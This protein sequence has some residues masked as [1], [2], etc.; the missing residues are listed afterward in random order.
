MTFSTVRHGGVTAT[1]GLLWKE[2]SSECVSN[3]RANEDVATKSRRR[4]RSAR[5]CAPAEERVGT[6]G[7]VL[8]RTARSVTTPARVRSC[9]RGLRALRACDLSHR[10]GRSRTLG[11]TGFSVGA[12]A[13]ARVA[14]VGHLRRR[15][16][17]GLAGPPSE[18]MRSIH[19]V[20]TRDGLE[21]LCL[22][23]IR[24]GCPRTRPKADWV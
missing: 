24:A 18:Y 3:R 19:L 21:T 14:P 6:N 17:A 7:S 12:M 10:L 8:D 20:A 15:A 5:P 9:K 4:A 13:R 23:S 22:G 11:D 16:G 1:V 2:Q